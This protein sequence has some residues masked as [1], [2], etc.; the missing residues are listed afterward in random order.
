MRNGTSFKRPAN[1][2]DEDHFHRIVSRERKRSERSGES[3][4][5]L[6]LDVSRI[7]DDTAKEQVLVVASGPIAGAIRETDACGW[8]NTGVV[9]GIIFTGI[10]DNTLAQAVQSV[11]LKVREHFAARLPQSSVTESDSPSLHFPERMTARLDGDDANALFY[12]EIFHKDAT[13]PR[14]RRLSSGRW[15][16]SAA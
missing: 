15:T 5:L 7:E 3:V 12:P 10:A 6:M 9:L 2:L 11:E 1:I 4:L 8:L 13:R 16:S 14:F